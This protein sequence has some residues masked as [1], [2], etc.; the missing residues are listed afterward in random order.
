MQAV[1]RL[2]S[3]EAEWDLLSFP[4]ILFGQRNLL[5][6]RL[7]LL[8]VLETNGWPVYNKPNGAWCLRYI[9]SLDRNS[10]NFD[11]LVELRQ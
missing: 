2:E 1:N 10:T 6:H 11:G 8:H 5:Y 4:D 3:N 7:F 9:C